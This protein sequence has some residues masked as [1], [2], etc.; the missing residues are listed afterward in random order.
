MAKVAYY[1]VKQ[2]G[3][4]W[5]TFK[6]IP[7]QLFFF[8]ANLLTINSWLEY[9]LIYGVCVGI[10][11][12]IVWH[13]WWCSQEFHCLDNW[14]QK[15][16]I[17][18][19]WSNTSTH[20]LEFNLILDQCKCAVCSLPSPQLNSISVARLFQHEVELDLTWLC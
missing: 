3:L 12:V 10:F 6:G 5:R 16:F 15:Y 1:L 7:V 11:V 18:S 9:R 4:D 13:I 17:W 8:F 20:S 14:C 2:Q 19:L